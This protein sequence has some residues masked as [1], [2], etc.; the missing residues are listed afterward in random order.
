MSIKIRVRKLSERKL[1]EIVF[2]KSY[3]GIHKKGS[4]VI[5]DLWE[6]TLGWFATVKN[7]YETVC[8]MNSD[9]Y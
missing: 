3:E 6:T 7:S 2:Y 8:I 4:G 9:L 5:I 1:G